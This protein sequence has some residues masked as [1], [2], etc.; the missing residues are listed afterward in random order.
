MGSDG[1][2]DI[3]HSKNKAFIYIFWVGSEQF[4]QFGNVNSDISVTK[5]NLIARKISNCIN[6]H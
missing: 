5:G 6:F 4:S 1:K 2:K 3:I